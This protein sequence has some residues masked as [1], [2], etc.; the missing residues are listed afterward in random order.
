M[1]ITIYYK[2]LEGKNEQYKNKGLGTMQA[3]LLF[4]KIV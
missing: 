2:L 1:D 4:F 3:F